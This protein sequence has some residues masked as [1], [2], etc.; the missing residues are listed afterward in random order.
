MKFSKIGGLIISIILLWSS[1]VY[2]QEMDSES[3]ARGTALG[4]KFGTLGWGIEVVQSLKKN[5]NAR[6]GLNYYSGNYDAT[7]DDLEYD[8]DVNLYSWSALLDWYPYEGEFRVSGGIL[9]NGN[10]V[11][12]LGE[13]TDSI[14]IGD[15]QY[16]P[17]AI[18]D[19][20]Y[21]VGFRG[22]SPYLGIGFGNAI[23]K[24]RTLSFA[25]DLGFVFQ[26]TPDVEISANG[27]IASD[28]SF[29]RDLRKEEEELEDD[30][31]SIKYYPVLSFGFTYRFR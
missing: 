2:A 22:I 3:G 24:D 26:G 18:G 12:I 11:D 27:W 29:R 19:L 10:N 31:S 7:G 9:Y 5:L 30:I 8:I 28:Q 13:P 23:G 14:K 21:E 25:L 17:S 6:M 4:G 1:V 20:T 15:T 16:T